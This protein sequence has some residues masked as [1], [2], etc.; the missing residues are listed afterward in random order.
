MGI[1]FAKNVLNVLFSFAQQ[2]DLIPRGTGGVGE[3][4]QRRWRAASHSLPL[5]GGLAEGTR[6]VSMVL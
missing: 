3:P 4:R 5:T 1:Y 2:R 6:D